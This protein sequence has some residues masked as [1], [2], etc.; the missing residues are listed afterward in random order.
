MTTHYIQM[1]LVLFNVLLLISLVFHV[2]QLALLLYLVYR[3]VQDKNAAVSFI[4]SIWL[5][6]QEEVIDHFFV[7]KKGDVINK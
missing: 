4:K 3:V 6:L 1:L 2:L 7:E 5:Q